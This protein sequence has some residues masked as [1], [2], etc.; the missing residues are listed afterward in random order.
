MSNL[1]IT[2]FLTG[3][4]QSL[5][6]AVIGDVML[7][8]YFYGTV[9]RI[10]PEAPVPVVKINQIKSVLGGAANVAANLAKLGCKTY[11]GGVT[12]NDENLSSLE[13]LIDGMRIDRKGIFLSKHRKTITKLRVLGGQQQMLRMDFEENDD[14]YEDEIV[15]LSQWLQGLL[16]KGLQ[17]III[18]DYAKGVCSDKFCQWVI[19]QAKIFKVPVLV[20]PKG[21]AWK[22]YSGCD[23]ITPNVK[24]ICDAIGSSHNNEDEEIILMAREVQRRYDIQ[25]VVVTRSEKGITLVNNQRIMHSP[26][27]ALDVFDVSGAG[28]TVAATLMASI[29]GGL[30][31]QQAIFIANQA[32][33]IEVGKVGTYPVSRDEILKIIK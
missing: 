6:I 12:G 9:N 20:D 5:K 16:E 18:S 14:L 10:S 3:K 24:E 19:T 23:Y 11:I 1:T 17:G 25:N 2:Q 7:D 31:M 13:R 32:A 33:G 29:V 4:I 22:K 8:Q 28:D 15:S 26:A 21:N 30:D 27:T